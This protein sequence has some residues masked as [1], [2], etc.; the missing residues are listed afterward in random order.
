MSKLISGKLVDE[1]SRC[2]HWHGDLDIIALKFKCCPNTYYSC[3][4][5]HQEL[6]NH[7]VEKYN[8]LDNKVNLIIC[9]NCR[10]EFTFQE[11]VT[12]DYKCLNCKQKFNPGCK[13]HYD[14]YFK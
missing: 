7:K 6:C 14:M 5:C 12:S 13:L 11:Y 1:K 3:Y 9:G 10:K 2:I 8:R 4:T